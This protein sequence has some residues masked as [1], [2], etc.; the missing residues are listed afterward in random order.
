MRDD[1]SKDLYEIKTACLGD[2]ITQTCEFMEKNC[3]ISSEMKKTSNT[4][5]K[6][7]HEKII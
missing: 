2:D 7:T 4:N 5:Y 1:Y 3:T 6:L